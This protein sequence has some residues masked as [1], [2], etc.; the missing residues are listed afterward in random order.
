MSEH[1]TTIGLELTKGILDVE[2]LNRNS[3]IC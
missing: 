1:H 2:V 3:E